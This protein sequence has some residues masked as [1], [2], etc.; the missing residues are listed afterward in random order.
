MPSPW[1]RSRP[2]CDMFRATSRMDDPWSVCCQLIVR[3]NGEMDECKRQRTDERASK[4]P[5][6]AIG[7]AGMSIFGSAINP[8]RRRRAST[9]LR[10]RT[11]SQILVRW[12]P[13]TSGEHCPNGRSVQGYDAGSM[14]RHVCSAMTLH[15]RCYV[16]RTRSEL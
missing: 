8:N 7:T 15:L 11:S 2:L 13:L 9:R 12:S 16:G 3:V 14:Y 1:L 6:R 4:I 5:P 10:R